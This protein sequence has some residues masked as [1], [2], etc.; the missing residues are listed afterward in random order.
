MFLLVDLDALLEPQC[1]WQEPWGP[2]A[3]ILRNVIYRPTSVRYDLLK[4]PDSVVIV[5]YREEM[6]RS[7]TESQL[8][9]YN[10]KYDK[11]IMRP[12]GVTY[13]S[14]LSNK[15]RATIPAQSV[16]YT[17]ARNPKMMVK[18]QSAGYRVQTHL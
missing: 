3:I 10:I 15:I 18:L 6:L 8:R 9:L 12:N 14:W 17:V 13:D 2:A 1:T 16:R 11:L 4:Y 5:T 7:F